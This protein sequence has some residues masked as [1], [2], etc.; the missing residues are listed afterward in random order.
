MIARALAVL[1]TLTAGIAASPP[2]HA[3]P[4]PDKVVLS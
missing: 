4:V 1:L 3:A 2:A